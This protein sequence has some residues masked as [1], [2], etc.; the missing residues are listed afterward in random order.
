[1]RK[2]Q[3]LRRQLGGS[4]AL[5][6][7]FPEKPPAMHEKRYLQIKKIALSAEEEWFRRSAYLFRALERD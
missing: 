5:E 2:A 3:K 6:G 7:P 1:M 4:G